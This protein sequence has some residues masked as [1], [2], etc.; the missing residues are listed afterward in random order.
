V[1]GTSPR[2][3]SRRRRQ[4]I[5]RRR[6]VALAALVVI[7]VLLVVVLWPGASPPKGAAGVGSVDSPAVVVSKDGDGIKMAT[8]LGT[9]SRRFY[10]LGP[11]PRRLDLIWK[12]RIGGGWTSGKFA[13]DPNMYW[14]GTG[15]TGMPALVKEGGTLSLLV[16]GYDHKLHR[17]DAATGKIVWAYDFGDVIKSSPSVIANP[18][19]TSA[20]DKYLVLAGSRRG[21]GLAMGDPRIA[22][23]RAVTFGS[24]REV[25]RLPV[26][27]TAS[28][29]Q[30]VDASGFALDGLDYVGVE[31]GWFYAL[32]PFKTQPWTVGGQTWRKPVVDR[33]RLLIGT[34]A[35]ARR[36]RVVHKEGV[37]LALEASPALLGDT[38]FVSSG[39]GHVYGLRRSDLAVAFDYR[40]GSDLD[41][42]AVATRG[43]RLLVPIEHQYIKGHGG[44]MMLDPT[45]PAAQSPVW[46]F[47][48][49]N[50]KVAEWTG[51]VIGS[52]AVNDEYGGA[53]RYPPL[54]AFNAIDG[55]LY[56]VSQDTLAPG[57]LR[58]P[59]LERG[60][61]TPVT[62][63]KSWVNSAVSTPI[64]VDDTIVDAAYDNRVHLYHVDYRPAQ[65]GA[66]DALR[67]R[68][69][70]WWTIGISQTATFTAGSAFEST[71]VLWDGR[72]YVG[73][74]DG[75]FYC[76]GDR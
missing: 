21:F 35:D 31:P 39:A 65:P 75:W 48:T 51:G 13:T 19:P 63:F 50:R 73:C 36:D 52:V 68:D 4:Q 47:P 53:D 32:D 26:P 27:R 57:T 76:L 61:K 11:A 38:I 41:G 16:G 55:N 3:R 59:N 20:D 74:R 49:G 44:V 70:H 62:V 34:P 28:Y 58:G 69:G 24:G 37:N 71:P 72:I 66:A 33:S 54:A 46:F 15:W 56:V 22:S 64:V 40:T 18:H 12:T 17:I 2:R 5:A 14:S 9:A 67:S 43:G 6:A 29:T 23:Y 1:T 7:L 25:W 60:M 10:G 42:T 30:D 45:K 8:F